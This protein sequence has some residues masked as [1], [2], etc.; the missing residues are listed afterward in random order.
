M[1]SQA[2]I[3]EQQARNMSAMEETILSLTKSAD[4]I[5]GASIEAGQL[6]LV[7]YAL[8]MTSMAIVT[9]D[10]T[11]TQQ[12]SGLFNK[13][14]E[15]AKSNNALL[16]VEDFQVDNWGLT[17]PKFS[18]LSSLNFVMGR[19]IEPPKLSPLE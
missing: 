13:V 7:G 2:K 18:E 12:G 14:K 10:N 11:L 1:E 9:E 19:V 5:K 15:T 3:I 16:G 6:G 8:G 17:L 4:T